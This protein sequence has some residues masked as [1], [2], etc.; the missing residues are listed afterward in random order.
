MDSLSLFFLFLHHGWQRMNF[1]VGCIAS[2]TNQPIS[3]KGIINKNKNVDCAP[4]AF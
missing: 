3:K 4:S 1:N 2:W